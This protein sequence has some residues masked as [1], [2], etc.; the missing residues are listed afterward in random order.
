MGSQFDVES[1][2]WVTI[3][4]WILTWDHISTWNHYSDYNSTWNYDLSSLQ[5]GYFCRLKLQKYANRSAEQRNWYPVAKA[6]IFAEVLN[7]TYRVIIQR[8]EQNFIC[9]LGLNDLMP[10]GVGGGSTIQHEN[11]LNL[12]HSLLNKN[13]TDRNSMGVIF[14]PTSVRTIQN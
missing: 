11:L 7:R 4:C 12:E 6:K 3:Q 9:R 8:R 10:R 1:Y 14:S 13:P 2:S 5:G